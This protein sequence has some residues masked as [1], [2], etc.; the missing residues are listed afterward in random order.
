MWVNHRTPRCDGIIGN[1]RSSVSRFV[2]CL[3]R[4]RLE[5]YRRSAGNQNGNRKRTAPRAVVPLG[6][7][8]FTVGLRSIKDLRAVTHLSS[9]TTT[10]LPTSGLLTQQAFANRLQSWMCVS[11]DNVEINRFDSIQWGYASRVFVSHPKVKDCWFKQACKR[12]RIPALAR[13]IFCLYRHS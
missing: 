11:G 5:K 2:S 4:L 10:R 9:T 6:A 13:I 12:Y 3:T 1:L 7:K 8:K